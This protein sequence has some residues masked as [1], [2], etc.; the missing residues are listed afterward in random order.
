LIAGDIVE[1]HS[2]SSYTVGTVPDQSVTNAKVA[3]GAGIDASKLSFTQA[4][5]GAV[6]RTVDS[7]LKDVVS[8]KDFGAVGDGVADDTA[9]IQ[10]AIDSGKAAYV[11]K[12]TYKISATLN[13]NNGYKALIGDPSMPVITKTTAGSAIRIGTTAGAVLNEYSRVENLFLKSLTVAPTFPANPGP[14]DAGLALDGSSSSLPAA[15]Q[16]AIVRNVRIGNWSVGIYTNDVVACQIDRCF[17][18]LLVDYSASGGY[19]ASNKFAG[20]LLDCTPYTPGGISPQASIEFL[21]CDV[22]ATGTPTA[23][24]SAGYYLVGSDLRDT[25]FDRC[26]ATNTTYGWWIAT[27]GSDYHWDVQISRPIIDAFKTNGILIAGA[28]GPGC[29]SI[30]G[31]YFV[32]KDGSAG[33]CIAASNSNG[34]SITGGAQLLGLSNDGSTDDGIRLDSCNS[35]SIVGNSFQNCNYGVSLN[36]SKNCSIVGNHFF[37][38]ATAT[39][40]NPALFDAIRLFSAAEENTIVGNAIKGKD[41]TDVYSNGV[42]VASGCLRN[43]I[44]GNTVDPTS[45]TSA[46]N[47]SDTSTTLLSSDA[48]L[49][50][51]RTVEI[52]SSTADLI[53]QGGD[54]THAVRF[55]DSA[56][57]AKAYVTESGHFKGAGRLGLQG[58]DAS[59]PIVFYDGGGNAIAKINNSGVY[60]TGAP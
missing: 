49:I 44:V 32:G 11:P 31:G 59:Y 15:V 35:C 53:L 57:V 51:S 5:T 13:L 30:H 22:V 28:T 3:A 1:V 20:F 36:G 43:A 9:A 27:S 16:N 19:T 34:I 42:L 2:S 25:F 6:A 50:S 12:G 47:I 56:G 24:T 33:A 23:V 45:V 7:K 37:A 21:E 41:G 54:G 60:S 38:S 26:E 18:Q 48:L 52:K 58:N 14:N 46:Y 4:G 17:A 40:A 39:E 55:R 8:V 10:A 29:I